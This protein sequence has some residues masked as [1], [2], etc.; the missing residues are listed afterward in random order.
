VANLVTALEQRESLSTTGVGHGVAIPHVF[1]NDVD[2]TVGMLG[3][4]SRG[5]PYQAI[6]G[7]PVHL[8]FLLIGPP[9]REL[10]HLQIL[11]RLSRLLSDA[12]TRRRLLSAESREAMFDVLTEAESKEA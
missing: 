5:I 11:S 6:D 4:S 12:D 1:T 3:R 7:A 9:G 2:R 8:V 10:N